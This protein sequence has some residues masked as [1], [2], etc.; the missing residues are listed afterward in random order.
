DK[1]PRKRYLGILFNKVTVQTV[2][3]VANRETPVNDT[4]STLNLTRQWIL[5]LVNGFGRVIL[6]S[7]SSRHVKKPIAQLLD[8]DNLVVRDDSIEDYLWQS[9]DYPTDTAL[10]RMK[11]G[12][13]MKI[14][15]RGF[16]WSWKNVRIN[17]TPKDPTKWARGNW[18]KGCVRKT[19]FN[20]KNEVKF[21]K[22]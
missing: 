8:S 10:P 13:D 20:F 12:I 17:F 5:T 4:S 7:N 9:F 22:Y 16:L 2:V 15:F 3:W 14:G 21:L 6:S 18:S 11:L 1:F 19:L